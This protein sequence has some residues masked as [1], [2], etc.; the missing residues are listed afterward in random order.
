MQKKDCF[1]VGKIVK[2][3]SFKGAV[4]VKLDTDDP[5]QF[6]EMESVFLEQHQNLVPFFIEECALHKSDL[7]RIKFE[8]VNSDKEADLLIGCELFLPLDLLPKLEGNQFYY[9]EV[10]GFQ[11]EDIHYGSVGTLKA[12][13]DA[14]AQPLFI[15]EHQGKEVLIPINDDFLLKVDRKTKTIVLDTP[16]GLIE[17][18]L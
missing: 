2:K 10:V 4:L 3:F 1:F 9:H 13:N 6:T 17:L 7:L 16:E 14:S 15:I 8:E 18:Y 12:V 5:E 11:V